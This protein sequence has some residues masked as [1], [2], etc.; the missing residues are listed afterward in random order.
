VVLLS[1]VRSNLLGGNRRY[2]LARLKDDIVSV[3]EGRACPPPLPSAVMEIS[4]GVSAPGGV[5]AVTAY[6]RLKRERAAE[7]YFDELELNSL[8]LQ[9]LFR[10]GRSHEAIAVLALNIEEHPDSYNVYDTM[11]YVLLKEGRT[12]EAIDVYRRGIAVFNAHPAANEPYRADLERAVKLVAEQ[13]ARAGGQS[14]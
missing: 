6:R 1:N 5:D 10:A 11:G 2:K 12:A 13:E 7:Y 9:L 4:R 14:R 3:L 8:G